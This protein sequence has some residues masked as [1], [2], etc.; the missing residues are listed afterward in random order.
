MARP[1]YFKK[2][3][4]V[5]YE[6]FDCY[7]CPEGQVLNYRTT[8]RDGYRQY[9]S[10]PKRCALCPVLQNCTQAA[11]PQKLIQCHIWEDYLELSEDL[12]H[13]RQIKEAYN[14]RKETIERVFADAKEKHGML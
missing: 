6:H 4:Y 13:H 14:R 3:D 2:R 1:G 5:Y 9:A 7:L 10:D 8:P 12:R 11:K